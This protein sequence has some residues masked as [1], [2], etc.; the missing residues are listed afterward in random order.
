MRIVEV[1]LAIQAELED[2]QDE[3]F[4]TVTI[5]FEEY[6]LQELANQERDRIQRGLP[7]GDARIAIERYSLLRL[8]LNKAAEAGR[9]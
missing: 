8:A 3:P 7:V 4:A 9:G 6:E 5:E 1:K 2:A